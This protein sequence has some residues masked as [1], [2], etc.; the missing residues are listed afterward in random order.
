MKANII[1]HV[2]S[3]DNFKTR[4]DKLR[5]ELEKEERKKPKISLKQIFNKIM[6]CPKGKKKCN[7]K[8]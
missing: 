2:L 7:C 1:K 6:K 3:K 4:R 8:K 5:K